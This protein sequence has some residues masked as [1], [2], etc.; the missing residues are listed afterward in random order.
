MRAGYRHGPSGQRT[1]VWRRARWPDGRLISP[2]D[3][4]IPRWVRVIAFAPA[5][6]GIWLVGQSGLPVSG[7]VPF[8]PL[9]LVALVVLAAC[10]WLLSNARLWALT[11]AAPPAEVEGRTA[12]FAASPVSHRLWRPARWPDGRRVGGGDWVAVTL[13][14]AGVALVIAADWVLGSMDVAGIDI[15][16]RWASVAVL[17]SLPASLLAFVSNR[18]IVALAESAAA[19]GPGWQASSR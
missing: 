14:W 3:D 6:V 15:A 19:E 18:R 11:E 13:T 8:A 2:L 12:R 7:T 16:D 5:I 9:V 4:G 1:S 17:V 10:C